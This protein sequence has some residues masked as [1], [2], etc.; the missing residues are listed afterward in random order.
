MQRLRHSPV[1]VRSELGDVTLGM[2]F[3]RGDRRC[4]R[5]GSGWLSAQQEKRKNRSVVQDADRGTSIFGSNI[6]Q[7]L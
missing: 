5:S 1:C 4:R 6:R 2:P 7:W 3:P